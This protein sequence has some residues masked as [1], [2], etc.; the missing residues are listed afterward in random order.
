MKTS[1]LDFPYNARRVYTA[2]KTILRECGCFRSIKEDERCF[3]LTAS[4]GMPIFGE[5]LTINII[6]T[7]STSCEVTMKSTDKILFNPF[8]I[9]NNIRIV[10]DLDQFISNEVY[11]LCSPNE[12]RINTPEIRLSQP[13]IKLRNQ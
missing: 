5:D 6:A 4:K 1:K 10:K 3:R 8:K 13:E 7:S 11:R 12:L 2:C 9:G